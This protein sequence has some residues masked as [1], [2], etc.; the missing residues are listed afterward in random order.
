MTETEKY[1]SSYKYLAIK[2]MQ[3]A[4]IPASITL[5]QAILES[6]VGQSYIARSGNN[7][8]GIKCNSKW[9]GPSVNYDDDTA[10][11]CFRSYATV[12][13]S[14]IDH[15]D[16]L[17][18]SARYSALF[19]LEMTDYK[20]WATG[21]KAAGYATRSNYAELLIGIIDRYQL[22]EYD[23]FQTNKPASTE[24][25][26]QFVYNGIPAVMVREGDTYDNITKDN[27]ITMEK[28]VKYNDLEP[29]QPLKKDMILY[30]K[31]KKSKGKESYHIAKE[32][33]TMYK[34]SQDYGIKLENLLTMNLMNPNE[35]PAS[36]E[37]IYLK[38]KR[39]DPPALQQNIAKK[40]DVA[41][42]EPVE[43][44]FNETQQKTIEQNDDFVMTEKEPEV[45]V[46]KE[47]PVE[48]KPVVIPVT[49]TKKAEEDKPKVVTAENTDLLAPLPATTSSSTAVLTPAAAPAA[50]G[51]T[52]YHIVQKGETMYSISKLY[53]MK[54]SELQ[55]LNGMT[56]FALSVDQKLVVNKKTGTVT[57]SQPSTVSAP[58]KPSAQQKNVVAAAPTATSQS[59]SQEVLSSTATIAPVDTSKKKDTV[60][61][62]VQEGETFYSISRQYNVKITDIIAWN[63]I[64]EYKLEA[65]KKIVV[66][67][68]EQKYSSSGSVSTGGS[69]LVPLPKGSVKGTSTVGTQS[70][71]KYH[72]V[73]P[74]ETL[75]AISKMYNTTVDQLKE[76]N[77]MTDNSISIGQKLRVKP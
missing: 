45:E 46:V 71:D 43:S 68:P 64:K 9:T 60:Y 55:S 22:Y 58:V 67:A 36:G 50:A 6:S 2:E 62:V 32:G 42:D 17:A 28:L 11:E 77:S 52:D 12:E 65:G 48:V 21:L 40:E 35:M 3:R 14:Y 10:N 47:A 33:E 39:S 75:Y 44:V 57:T 23:K 41:S 7:H 18:G 31:T 37:I 16:F 38:Q 5:A 8:F 26:A 73:Q 15:S 70:D 25:S 4:K 34:I 56:D 69:V 59:V 30:L 1:I 24:K 66:G 51:A 53:G 74:K 13:E 72:V 54:V 27:K 61:H 20:G 29:N 63:H 49:E 76:W 19:Q